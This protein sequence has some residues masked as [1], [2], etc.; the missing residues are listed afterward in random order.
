MC[1]FFS[2]NK[3]KNREES[4]FSSEKSTMATAAAAAATTAA[5]A[6]AVAAATRWCFTINNYTD[7][8]KFWENEEQREMIKYLIVQ[9]EVGAQGTPHLQGFLILKKKHRMTWLKSNINGRAHWEKARG[10][11]QQAADYC[12]A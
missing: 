9:H 12:F 4:A 11:D 3:I 10:T 2:K 7:E 5:A 8:D 1:T 6:A